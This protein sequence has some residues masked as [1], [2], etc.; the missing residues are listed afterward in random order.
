MLW[1][2][3]GLRRGVV[4]TRYPAELDSWTRTL[5]TPPTFRPDLLTDE[6]ALRLERACASRALR[7]VDGALEVDLGRCTGGRRCLEIAGDAAAT[8][9]VVEL[10]ATDREA[11]IKRVRIGGARR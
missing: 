9:G 11:L 5:P 4:T 6:L 3:R 2:L 10:A 8:S 7:R 1:F